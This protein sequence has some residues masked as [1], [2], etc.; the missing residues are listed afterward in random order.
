MDSSNNVLNHSSRLENSDIYSVDLKSFIETLMKILPLNEDS[1][2]SRFANVG[3]RVMRKIRNEINN[4]SKTE[5]TIY[6]ANTLGHSAGA[7]FQETFEV[8]NPKYFRGVIEKLI[9]KLE[10]QQKS[11]ENSDNDEINEIISEIE[12]K[13]IPILNI[14]EKGYKEL[15]NGR[16]EMDYLMKQHC[17]EE[18]IKNVDE[19]IKEF[20]EQINTMRKALG[21]GPQGE[22]HPE[23]KVSS[24]VTEVIQKEQ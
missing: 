24:S 4:N 20:K 17:T 8:Q 5:A 6:S 2:S 18:D 11:S 23:D 9:A 15:I 10:K 22:D 14:F 19:L 21:L 1:T 3:F 12:E 13:L 16:N 7:L